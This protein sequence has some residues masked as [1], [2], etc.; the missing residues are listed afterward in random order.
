[1]TPHAELQQLA[2]DL[3]A[4]RQARAAATPRVRREPSAPQR[5][6]PTRKCSLCHEPSDAEVCSGCSGHFA[7]GGVL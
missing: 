5:Y 6:T 2:D 3:K 7:K 4:R 1:M